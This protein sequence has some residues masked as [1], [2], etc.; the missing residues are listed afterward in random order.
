[1]ECPICK[2]TCGF[3]FGTCINCGYNHLDNTYH[4]IEV[5]TEILKRLISPDMFDYLVA[6][7]EKWKKR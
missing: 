6:E 1:M 5:S 2:N 3:A 7:H 4:K